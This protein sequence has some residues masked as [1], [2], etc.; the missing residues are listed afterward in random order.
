MSTDLISALAEER[1]EDVR[2][3]AE[4]SRL[5]R[6]ARPRRRKPAAQVTI[7]GASAA[8]AETLERLADL[9]S[10]EVPSGP[11]LVAE[12]DGR[13]WAALSLRDGTVIADPFH[14][15]A[16]LTALLQAHAS[17]SRKPRRV[18]VLGRSRWSATNPPRRASAL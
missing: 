9:D 15:T 14:P 8:D 6:S 1:L 3:A 11:L 12:I 13:L 4:R 7:R 16:E 18:R 10:S 5:A 17:N 2:R